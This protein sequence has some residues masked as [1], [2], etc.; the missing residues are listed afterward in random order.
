MSEIGHSVTLVAM[1]PLPGVLGDLAPLLD[2]YGYLAIALVVLV[3]GFG[4][5]APGQTII[6]VGAVYAGAGRLDIAL[7][8]VI[9]ILAATTGDSI[10]YWIGRIGGRRLVLRFGRY[11]LLTPERLDRGERFYSGHGG[12]I[13]A[14]ARFVD[15][16][17]QVNGVIAGSIGMAWPRF[18]LFN[19]IGAVLWV[20]TWAGLG[21]LAGTRIVEVYDEIHRY[22]WVVLGAVALVV[23]VLVGRKLV[24][25]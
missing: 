14:F 3:E 12:K 20:G 18:L 15:G 24:R 2:H 4:L 25:R 7:V 23:L 1:P 11:V 9:A 16:L 10:G 19:A 8:A 13:V 17:R 22:Q 6:L 5:P 21:Y